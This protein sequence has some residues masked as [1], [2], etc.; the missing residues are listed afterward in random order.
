MLLAKP[1]TMIGV[2]D[3]ERKKLGFVFFVATEMQCSLGKGILGPLR[4]AWEVK[5]VLIRAG[6]SGL[7]LPNSSDSANPNPN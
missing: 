7:D 3:F 1:F 6:R 5:R 4:S 2:P